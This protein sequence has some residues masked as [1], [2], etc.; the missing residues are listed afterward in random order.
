MELSRE[1][2]DPLVVRKYRVDLLVLHNTDGLVFAFAIDDLIFDF[3][4]HCAGITVDEVPHLLV[5][6]GGC[7]AT[8]TQLVQMNNQLCKTTFPQPFSKKRERDRDDEL[9]VS[10]C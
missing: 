9:W 3:L 6:Q 8:K 5:Q 10:C 2:I 4:F 1:K 7:M